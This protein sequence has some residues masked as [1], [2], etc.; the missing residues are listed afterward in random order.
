M[1]GA[2]SAAQSMVFLRAPGM[3]VQIHK[4]RVRSKQVLRTFSEGV[5]NRKG[6]ESLGRALMSLQKDEGFAG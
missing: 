5:K 4:I 3:I 6:S 2:L 1:G